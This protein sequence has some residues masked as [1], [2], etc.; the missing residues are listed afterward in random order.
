M[1]MKMKRKFQSIKYGGVMGHRFRAVAVHLLINL[2]VALI[3]AAIVFGVW[4]PYPYN[5]VSGGWK[6]FL[7]IISIDVLIG[8]LC[9]LVIFDIKKPSR[10]LF[11]DVSVVVLLQIFALMYG[12]YTVYQARP[13]HLIFEYSVFRVVHA[14]D[15]SD[16]PVPDAFGNSF[17]DSPT[18]LSLRD[19]RNADEQLNA[20]AQAMSG[21][22]LSFRPEF[23]QPYKNA[24]KKVRAVAKPL[25]NLKVRFPR[26][27]DEIDKLAQSTNRPID[28]LSYV[29]MSSRKA[30]FWTVVL[31]AESGEIVGFLP[32]D[33]F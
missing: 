20:T 6:L 10:E 8:P 14:A 2:V 24:L 32:I 29:P 4:Y 19:F 28:H 31:D 25:A 27:I 9:T 17:F 26:N 30:F 21:L 15:V 33:S 3:A 23:W 7:M 16:V 11:L 1:A 22:E 12:L 13:L 5:H 18:M